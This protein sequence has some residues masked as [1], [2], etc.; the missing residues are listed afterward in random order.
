MHAH[1]RM[2]GTQVTQPGRRVLIGWTGPAD[3]APLAPVGSAQ[4]LPRELSLAPDRSLRQA[5]VPELQKLRIGGGKSVSGAAAMAPIAAGLQAEVVAFLPAAC[6]APPAAC[7]VSVLGDGAN[8]TRITLDTSSHL[9]TVDATS[10][11]RGPAP[12]TAAR[13]ACPT[14]PLPVHSPCPFT[15]SARSQPLPMR[16]AYARLISSYSARLHAQGNTAVRGGPLPPPDEATGGWHVHVFADHSIVEIIVGNAT[17]FVVYTLPSEQ[18]GAVSLVNLPTAASA[19]ELRVW[20]L[21]NASHS[22]M[23][24]SNPHSQQLAA[25]AA[26]KAGARAGS[27]EEPREQDGSFK[28]GA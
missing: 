11:V 27:A 5:F 24:S 26:A 18:A 9:V 6:V 19:A 13:R 28:G 22:Y 25:A 8:A 10:Q 21:A 14:Q 12:F 23:Y 4:S 2:H 3:A 16:P 17:A 1:V 20:P 7:G 15:A